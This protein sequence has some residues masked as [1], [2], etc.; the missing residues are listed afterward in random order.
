MTC[1]D[2][3]GLHVKEQEEERDNPLLVVLGTG[4]DEETEAS[5]GAAEVRVGKP[6]TS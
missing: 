1:I 5:T 6:P 4:S 3:W 2:R